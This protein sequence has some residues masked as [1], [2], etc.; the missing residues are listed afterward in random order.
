M[1]NPPGGFCCP[2]FPG[3]NEIWSV[4]LLGGRIIGEPEEKKPSKDEKEQKPT[5]N[6]WGPLIEGPG[7]LTCP[8]VK[9]SVSIHVG[10]FN[11][12]ETSL[13]CKRNKLDW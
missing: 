10:S 3:R 4:V 1:D 8:S 13:R 2:Q 12:F 9:C 6:A 11:S 5:C 7:S